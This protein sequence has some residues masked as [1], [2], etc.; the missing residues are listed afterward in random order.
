MLLFLGLGIVLAF[1][2]SSSSSVSPECSD[3][4]V[5]GNV[6]AS[7]TGNNLMV[8]FPSNYDYASAFAAPVFVFGPME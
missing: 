7:W 8:R 4:N 2:A 1:L 5:G 6:E 3:K